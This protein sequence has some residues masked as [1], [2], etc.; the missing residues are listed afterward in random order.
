MR[1]PALTARTSGPTSTTE[2]HRQRFGAGMAVAG[3]NRPPRVWRSPSSGL[4]TTMRSPVSRTS[5]FGGRFF[6]RAEGASA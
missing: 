1:S 4:R 5:S 2:D 3:I 6:L